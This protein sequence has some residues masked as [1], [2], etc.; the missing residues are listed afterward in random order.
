MDV[1]RDLS[2]TPGIIRGIMRKMGATGVRES[3]VFGSPGKEWGVPG[4]RERN[5]ENRATACR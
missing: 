2:R 4:S 3:R 5:G 1:S